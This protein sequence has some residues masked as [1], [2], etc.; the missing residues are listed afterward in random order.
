[1][2]NKDRRNIVK[3]GENIKEFLNSGSNSILITGEP[4]CGKTL[5]CDYLENSLKEFPFVLDLSDLKGKRKHKLKDLST[6]EYSIIL[7][8]NA[9]KLNIDSI[10]YNLENIK[11]ID[12][13]IILF[14]RENDVSETIKQYADNTFNFHSI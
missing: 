1:M 13:K 4:D 6:I 9:E 10:V 5:L 3:K 12:K 14:S 7:I 2:N 11:N 8:D